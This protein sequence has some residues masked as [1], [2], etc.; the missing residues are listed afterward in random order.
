MGIWVCGCVSIY[1]CECVLGIYACVCVCGS[2][3]AY[4]RVWVWKCIGMCECGCV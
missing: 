2:V 3:R 4:E 1:A